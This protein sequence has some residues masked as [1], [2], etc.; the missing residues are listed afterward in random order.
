MTKVV[1]I[2][3]GR[4]TANAAGVLAGRA[5]G[6]ALDDI[7]RA[8]AE[9]L[10]ETLRGVR[11]A[12]AYTSPVERCIETATLAG[13]PDAEILDGVSECDY[14][15]WTGVKLDDLSSQEVWAD[16]QARPSVVAFPGGES[17]QAMFQ[18]TTAA[19]SGLAERHGDD[20]V[21]VVFSHGDPI[22]AILAHAFGMHLDQFQRL[23]V[24]PA[25]ISVVDYAGERP[26]VVCVNTGGDLVSLLGGHSA[27][28]IGG[29][30]VAGVG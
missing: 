15:E 16:V 29:G 1:L 26:L 18:R 23:H 21:V 2:R 22:K 3:H 27:P 24:H 14:G 19:I 10:G 6:V 5:P 12:A 4:S 13:F 9:A 8:Q 30:D 7:G 11:V 25:G 20:E 17:M 28:T